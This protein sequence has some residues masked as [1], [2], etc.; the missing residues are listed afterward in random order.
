M[1]LPDAWP[2][3]GRGADVHVHPFF[4]EPVKLDWRDAH[5]QRQTSY[6]V[7]GGMLS[8]FP[9][10]VFERT[11]GKPPRW[12]T[13]GGEALGPGGHHGPEKFDVHDTLGLARAMVGTMAPFYDRMHIDDPCTI[14]R[15]VFVDTCDVNAT[16]FAIDR[17]TQDRL[18][19][20]GQ[21]A[22]KKFLRTWD[23][24]AHQ[25]TC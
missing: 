25:T 18:F 5:G 4:Y 20:S 14:A 17:A 8:N 19:Q 22:A 21:D 2:E 13:F 16:D 9:I 15:T 10:E 23:F 6:F 11:D 24:G 3:G 12:P 1:G 7:H